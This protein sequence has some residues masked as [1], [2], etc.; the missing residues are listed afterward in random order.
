MLRRTRLIATCG[1]LVL[2]ATA[3][4]AVPAG[5]AVGPTVDR[6]SVT[7][8]LEFFT[9]DFGN[10]RDM[11]DPADFI[12]DQGLTHLGGTSSMGPTDVRIE[13]ASQIFIM[14]S[15]NSR[16]P[17]AS[18]F[19]PVVRPL[20]ADLYRRISFRMH[21]SSAAAGALVFEACSG[22]SC[23]E[24]TRYFNIV[25][26]WK[27]YDI[28]MNATDPLEESV[29][30]AG[31]W[32]GAA[33]G[34]RI[35]LLH[36]IPAFN[37]PAKPI[38]TI[39]DLRITTNTEPLT[40]ATGPGATGRTLWMT[41]GGIDSL[42]DT[43]GSRTAAVV[44]GSLIRPG[45]A[46]QFFTREA[47]SSSAK[48]A[49]VS[50]D[51]T[52]RPTPRVTSLVGAA[53]LDWSTEVLGDP[54]DM[55]SAT[56]VPRLRN[57]TASFSDGQ[58]HAT[59]AG[60]IP[61]DPS[62]SLNL[63]G[64]LVDT[65]LYR[66]MAITLRYDGPWSLEDAPGGG[67]MVR[68]MWH[69]Q[70]TGV[71]RYQVSDDLVVG[72]GERTY[73]VELKTTPA[74]WIL[75]PAGNPDPV[76][77]GTAG[78][79]WIDEIRIDPHED[80][81]IRSWHVSDVK[82][83]RDHA[84]SPNIPIRFEDRTWRSGTVADITL[85]SDRNPDN[86]DAGRIA[87]GVSVQPGE[88]TLNWDSAG[89]DPGSYYVRVVMTSPTGA[90]SMVTSDAPLAIGQASTSVVPGADPGAAQRASWLRLFAFL[91]FVCAPRPTRVNGRMV[92]R[93]ACAKAKPPPKRSGKKRAVRRSVRR[94]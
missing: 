1:A 48:S 47:G 33:W 92:M 43:V 84:A 74:W 83:L 16:V 21:S 64:R 76:G 82:L 2:A 54:W 73:I 26:G 58:M 88:N 22:P 24:G 57:A 75:D 72:T 53:G 27:T 66:R 35:N 65:T 32:T 87:S 9:Q 30:G 18:L 36:M 52:T 12:A 29:P 60:P 13:G 28:L 34:G 89:S 51:P 67:M 78:A 85:D 91:A 80:P 14:R 71:D 63:G 79:P 11:S 46:A 4:E 31:S 45:E 41:S 44:P 42:I 20:N 6:G 23:R 50:M 49:A 15:V 70:G 86:G 40:I 25:A 3:L 61:N 93:S 69:L 10:A 7:S 55:E 8:P 90:R 94:R 59:T 68:V 77:W 38:L 17:Q 62:F 81:G 5:A 37:S 39:D 19:D 56:D